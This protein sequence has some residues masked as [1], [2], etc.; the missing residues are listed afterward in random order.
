MV[1]SNLPLMVRCSLPP[2]GIKEDATFESEVRMMGRIRHKNLVCLRG[3]LQHESSKIIVLDYCKNGSLE[4]ALT[5][6]AP[7]R[8]SPSIRII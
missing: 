4:D 8:S 2:Q 6:M 1:E 7:C 3:C 5:G